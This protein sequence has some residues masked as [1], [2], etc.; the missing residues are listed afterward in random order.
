MLA[1]QSL[2]P[3]KKGLY[4]QEMFKGVSKLKALTQPELL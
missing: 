2:T 1:P 3:H 4:G